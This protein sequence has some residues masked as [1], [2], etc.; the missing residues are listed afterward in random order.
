MQ[1]FQ[2]LLTTVKHQIGDEKNGEG[3]YLKAHMASLDPAQKPLEQQL[4]E[5]K[6]C[7]PGQQTSI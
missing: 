5:R 4:P 6:L 2:P 3:L 1:D 7:P